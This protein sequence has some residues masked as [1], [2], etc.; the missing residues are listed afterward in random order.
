MRK[1]AWFWVAL[2]ALAVVTILATATAAQPS[3]PRLYAAGELAADRPP[4][5]DGGGHAE[6]PVAD[7]TPTRQARPAGTPQAL[8]PAQ[9]SRDSA[10]T[11]DTDA[12][13]AAARDAVT[14]G[15]DADAI[16]TYQEVLVRDLPEAQRA[17]LLFALAGA[18][19]RAAR[20]A[21]AAVTLAT[22]RA[23]PAGARDP[24]VL[25]L[26][27]R[28][29]LAAGAGD[30]AVFYFWAYL[31][32]NTAGRAYAWAGLGDAYAQLGRVDDAR[33]C[34]G[35]ANRAGLPGDLQAG[36]PESLAAAQARA[37]DVDAAVAAYDRLYGLAT[38]ESE[39]GRLQFET[40]AVLLD[41]GRASE[42]YVRL[43]DIVYHIPGAATAPQALR[44]LL[45]AGQDIGPQ[46]QGV[47]AFRARDDEAA[48]ALFRRSLAQGGP[49]NNHYYMGLALA[50]LGRH[51][52]AVREFDAALASRETMD[53]WESA[54]VERVESLAALGRVDDAVAAY[55]ELARGDASY[56]WEAAD[57]LLASGRYTDALARYLDLAR[58]QRYATPRAEALMRA[59][60]AA[61][62]AGDQ[63]QA[64]KLWNG[65]LRSYPY[66]TRRPRLLLLLGKSALRA[67]KPATAE[68]YFAQVRAGYPDSYYSLRAQELSAQGP[69]AAAL[70]PVSSTLAIS[71]EQ[72]AAERAAADRWLAGWL[73]LPPADGLGALSPALQAD[74]LMVEGRLLWRMGLLEAAKA[75]FEALR[76]AHSSD[77]LSLYQLSIYYRDIGLY[78][79]SII[80]AR[81]VVELSPARGTLQAPRYVARLV[82]P[83]YYADLITEE[84]GRY[85]LDSLLVFS[86]I[87]QESLFEGFITSYASAA[88]LMQVMP[89]TG[90]YAAARLGWHD[91]VPA[92]L[93]EPV[94]SVRLGV[95]YLAEQYDRFDGNA[96]AALAAYNA[97]PSRSARWYAR[98]AGDP[99]VFLSLIDLGQPRAYIEEVFRNH[100]LYCALYGN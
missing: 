60:I 62:L 83:V 28:A 50:N 36:Q 89:A 65:I 79:S 24:A 33:A 4:A 10:A 57:V 91:F 75:D 52:E 59:G 26:L 9:P 56:R 49:Q 1:P 6:G 17:E 82:Y 47:V 51:T 8:P 53:V 68:Q 45:D 87:R 27:A 13:L 12:L 85:G 37:G 25:F 81:R 7:A 44:I 16:S 18:Q 54:R 72:D 20:P 80:A 77:A 96:Y 3:D 41:A 98:S 40:A 61:Y 66:T 21:D 93:Y 48:V 63:D 15:N 31:D 46:A 97:G 23:L 34:Y 19:M 39:R 95:W 14:R 73:K 78:R 94:A 99:D 35:Q 43:R 58:I 86:L 74:P 11:G 64:D 29:Q 38:T 67:G 90:A 55:D 5:A 2:S 100:A 92:R 84:T 88:G 70:E 32:A 69:E 71:P 42:A 22:L 76:Q 30:S